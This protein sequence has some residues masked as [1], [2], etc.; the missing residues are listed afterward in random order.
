MSSRSAALLARVA[1]F[2]LEAL[3]PRRFLS[4][5]GVGQEQIGIPTD[6]IGLRGH[7]WAEFHPATDTGWF[8][9][10]AQA[11]IVYN[12]R[13]TYHNL[14]MLVYAPD[15]ATRVAESQFD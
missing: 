3:E 7:G 8:S 2:E 5:D 10:E 15:G 6:A 13:N 14:R 4:A 9:F 1:M 11:G 12:I